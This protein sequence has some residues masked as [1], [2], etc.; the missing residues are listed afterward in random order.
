[1]RAEP[2]T[3]CA[4]C[5]RITQP[6]RRVL[7]WAFPWL[8]AAQVSR[9]YHDRLYSAWGQICD[10]IAARRPYADDDPSFL[11]SIGMQRDLKTGEAP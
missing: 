7:F 6:W 3:D 2:C 8:K 11:A 5:R 1:M 4:G 9:G 10:S